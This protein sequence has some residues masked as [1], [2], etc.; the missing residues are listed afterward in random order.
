MAFSSMFLFSGC[1]YWQE[2][3]ESFI[4]AHNKLRVAPA[5]QPRGLIIIQGC[6]MC[7]KIHYFHIAYIVKATDNA[8]NNSY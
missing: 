1:G 5:I 6:L 4:W 2:L 3:I 7:I 8:S